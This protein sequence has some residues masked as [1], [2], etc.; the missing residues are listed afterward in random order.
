MSDSTNPLD[1]SS[2]A[3]AV[4]AG[5][6]PKHRAGDGVLEGGLIGRRPVLTPARGGLPTGDLTDWIESHRVVTEQI[7]DESV[8]PIGNILREVRSV[9]ERLNHP[10]LLLRAG[11]DL[12]RGLTF[13][14]PP[15]TGKTLTARYLASHLGLGTRVYEFGGDEIEAGMVRPLFDYL[16]KSDVRTLLVIDEIE[17]FA[18]ARNSDSHTESTRR[19]LFAVLAT[20]EGFRAFPN[21]V[22]IGTTNESAYELDAAL[23]RPGRVGFKINLPTPTEK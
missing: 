10:E 22:V 8:V 21:V 17:I 9:I 12:P 3:K 1:E 18:L 15:G 5:E 20:L 14:G 6:P 4:L 19:A 2:A 13:L 23:L 16:A 11:G 7:L